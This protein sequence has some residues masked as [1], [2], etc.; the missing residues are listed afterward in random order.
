MKAAGFGVIVEK[1][2]YSPCN[3]WLKGK[4]GKLIRTWDY[5]N[6]LDGVAAMSMAALTRG[7][8]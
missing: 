5:Q 2:F 4:K 3:A 8:G 7:A 1:H 6:L